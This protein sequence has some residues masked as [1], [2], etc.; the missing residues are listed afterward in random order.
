MNYQCSIGICTDRMQT[1]ETMSI[2]DYADIALYKAKE[3]GRDRTM[4]FEEVMKR[5]VIRTETTREQLARAIK[6]GTDADIQP[7]LTSLYPKIKINI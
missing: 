1:N 3:G 4:F 2:F 6:Q 5:E 7:M